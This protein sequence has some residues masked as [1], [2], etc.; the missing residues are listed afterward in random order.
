MDNTKSVTSITYEPIVTQAAPSAPNR[1]IAH[2]FPIMLR[3]AAEAVTIRLKRLFPHATK[4][5][6]RMAAMNSN[7]IDQTRMFKSSFDRVN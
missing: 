1:G 5:V 3:L 7:G 2:I 4:A 6:P